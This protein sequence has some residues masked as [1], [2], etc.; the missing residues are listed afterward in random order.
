MRVDVS[1]DLPAHGDVESLQ[2]PVSVGDHHEGD[3]VRVHVDRV[4]PRN[5][6]ADLE[7]T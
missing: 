4:V 1:L 2:L 7:L 6:H 3:V 5:S